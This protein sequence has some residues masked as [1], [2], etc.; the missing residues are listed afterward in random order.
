MTNT[1]RQ[2]TTARLAAGLSAALVLAGG[3][4]AMSTSSASAIILGTASVTP[5]ENLKTGDVVTATIGGFPANVTVYGVQCDQKVEVAG[6][7][8]YCDLTN[9]AV[10]QTDENGNGTGTFTVK[11]GADFSSANGL[12]ACNAKKPCDLA[13]SHGEGESET[14]AIAGLYFG[15]DTRTFAK[16]PSTRVRAGQTAVLKAAVTARSEGVPTG[17]V[18]VRD[19]GKVVATLPVPASGNVKV[20]RKLTAGVHK[21]TVRYN[22]DEAFLPSVDTVR[23]V[24]VK[25]R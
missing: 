11:S 24:A 17:N 21:L 15:T 2:S 23:V 1:L 7:N 25:K 4:V 3:M 8:T 16:T 5:S 18:V 10:I 9:F 6:D 22:G 19:N 14:G 20:E 12:G 13:F